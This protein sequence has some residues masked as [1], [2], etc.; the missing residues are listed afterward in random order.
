MA[1]V[2]TA[3]D[4]LLSH[5]ARYYARLIFAVNSQ[6]TGETTRGTE[7]EWLPHIRRKQKPTAAA[8]FHI[9]L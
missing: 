1:T 4:Y 7:G 2:R 3:T 5:I 8:N 9:I 6:R